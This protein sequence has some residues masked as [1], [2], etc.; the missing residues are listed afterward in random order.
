VA[1]LRAP[2]APPT[3][4]RGGRATPSSAPATARG[5]LVRISDLARQAGVPSATIKHY[6][7][8]GLLPRPTARTSRNMAYYDP[9]LAARVRTIKDLQTRRFLPLRLIGDLLEPAPS[10]EVRADA[11][12]TL[13]RHLGELAP[14]IQA[15]ADDARARRGRADRGDRAEELVAR[16]AIT[17]DELTGLAE[18]GLA[19]P[20]ADGRYRDADLELIEVIDETRHRGLGDLF[21]MAILAPYAEAVRA[22]VRAELEMFRV[23]VLS[24]AALPPRPLDDVARDA[25]RLGERL[26]V[27]MRAKLIIAELRALRGDA[28]PPAVTAT[29]RRSR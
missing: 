6:M 29:R 28:S 13:R 17:A 18:A 4:G 12:A 25:T 26:V 24:G 19:G 20:G 16:C 5:A 2:N 9:R 15:G 8:E 14:A 11:E 23:R 3:H 21:P 10:A 1:R 7:R 22:L 27:A